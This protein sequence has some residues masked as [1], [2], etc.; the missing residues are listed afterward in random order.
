[1]NFLAKCVGGS[2]SYGLAGPD[3]DTDYRGVFIN[4]DISHI[5]GMTKE[6]NQTSTHKDPDKNAEGAYFELRHF[7]QLLRKTNTMTLEILFNEDWIEKTPAFDLILE[8]KFEL[9]DTKRFYHSLG[10]YMTNELRLMTGERT[11]TL[12]GK[13]KAALDKYGYSPKNAVNLIRLCSAGRCFFEEGFFPLKIKDQAMHSFLW[14]VKN[15]PQDFIVEYL[16]GFISD[17]REMFE[18]A[19]IHK[20]FNYIFNEDVANDL[21]RKIYYPYIKRYS[22]IEETI[23]KHNLQPHGRSVTLFRK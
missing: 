23:R 1:M 9:L 12:G 18:N 14:N 4:T 10:S 13:R 2:H 21:L 20:K 15:N 11:G 8:Q 16:I 7:M 5:L 6:Q 19:Y 17:E 22:T 3:S